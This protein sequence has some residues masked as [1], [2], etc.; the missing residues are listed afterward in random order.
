[1][2]QVSN[3]ILLIGSKGMAGH[4]IL[5]H[6]K[7]QNIDVEHIARNN[8][9]F[10]PTYTVDVTETRRLQEIIAENRYKAVINCVGILNN[11][12]SENPDEAVFV[13][14]YIPHFLAKQ[15]SDYGGRLI[16]LSTD[17]VFSGKK[18]QYREDDF[19]DGYTMYAQTK[20]LGE[21]GYGNNL[22]IRTSIIGPELKKS[23][24]GLLNWFLQQKGTL[25]GYN[26]A[27]WSGVTTLELAKA[28]VW[29]LERSQITGTVHLTNGSKISKLELL[30]LFQ[31]YIK[32]GN[33]TRIEPFEEFHS[34]KSLI[35]TRSDVNYV[36]PA[37]EDMLHMLAE[38]MEQHYQISEEYQSV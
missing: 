21:V 28:I 22:T 10:E 16:H 5:Q 11:V 2:G 26:N 3:K 25:K 33:V 12:A 8:T 23:G 34:D 35:N 24:I 6:L 15:V 13:N 19:R 14:S 7:E 36:V 1:M 32:N 38:W 27:F 37:Y 18:G 4:V 9:H 20:I 31:R 17:C 29:F 30:R